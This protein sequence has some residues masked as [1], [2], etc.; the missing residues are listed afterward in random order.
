MPGPKKGRSVLEADDKVSLDDLSNVCNV[1]SD[2]MLDNHDVPTRE[3]SC[4]KPPKFEPRRFEGN[5]ADFPH[6]VKEIEVMLEGVK[7]SDEMKLMY[8]L[9]YCAGSASS[10]IQC[11]KF[12]PPREGYTEAMHILRQRFGRPSMIVRN[13]FETVKGNGSQLR[14][15]SSTLTEFL[16]NLMTYK[17]AL[18]SMNCM[19]DLNSSSVLE[20]IARRYLL[21]CK[22]NG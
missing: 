3:I 12:L 20:V 22:G 9:R 21:D 11:C 13:V 4:L 8:L 18:V 1:M 15:D 5:P 14:D 10:A 17:N 7:L 6:F 16:D 2:V 19:N